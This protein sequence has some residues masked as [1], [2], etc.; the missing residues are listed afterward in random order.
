[1]RL[2]LLLA[3]AIFC[4]DASGQ[5]N[6]PQGM[7]PGPDIPEIGSSVFDKIFSKRGANGEVDYD[8][9][10]PLS[11]LRERLNPLEPSLVHTTLPFSRSLQRPFDLSFDPLLNPR[12]VFAFTKDTASQTRAR[13]FMGYVKAKDQLEVI[14]YNDEAGRFEFQIVTDYSRKPRVFY[15]NRGKCLSCHQAQ[16]P[17]FSPPGWRDTAFGVMGDLMAV[18]LGLGRNDQAGRQAAT[19][20]L[21][22]DF[23]SQDNVATF[24][25][26]VR[27]ADRIALDERIWRDGC[28]GDD[29]CRLGLLLKTVS[30]NARETGAYFAHSRAVIEASALKSQTVF[31]SFLVSTPLNVPRVVEKFGS[32]AEVVNNPAALLD[33]ISHLYNLPEAENPATP[34]PS[35]LRTRDLAAPLA[36]FL[37]SDRE[38][39][40]QEI[41]DQDRV[42]KMLIRRFESGDRSL[43]SG[44]VQKNRVMS[45]LL[46][47][48]GSSAAD[49]YSDW[50][51]KPTPPKQLFRGALPPVFQQRELNLFSRHCAGCHAAGL[52]FP[53][54]FLLGNEEEVKEKIMALREK[55]IFKLE[56]NLMP[57]SEAGRQHLRESGDYEVLI[58]YLRGIAAR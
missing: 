13:L 17:I 16:A 21:F 36:G 22:G 54:Q 24:D 1:M 26:L 51:V 39:L 23:G 56:G 28:G 12:L 7:D 27:E 58:T 48:A 15:V 3:S 43:V 47:E 4:L 50:L 41:R 34:R 19:T 57:P 53:P 44:P 30:P 6:L 33:I 20:Q 52:S 11:R 46:N 37:P 18:K 9:P 29:A 8:L 10:F 38:I 14:S 49:V 55:M 45:A 42:A 35:S 5:G 32:L 2:L 25:L 40:R 31:S